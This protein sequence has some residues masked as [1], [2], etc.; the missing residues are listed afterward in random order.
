MSMKRAQSLLI[1][2][3]ALGSLGCAPIIRVGPVFRVV[4]TDSKMRVGTWEVTVPASYKKR[5]SPTKDYLIA[6]NESI[7]ID[8]A[9]I[10]KDRNFDLRRAFEKSIEEILRREKIVTLKQV[11]E[12]GKAHGL[13]SILF[14]A[15]VRFQ[16]N[17]IGVIMMLASESKDTSGL[18]FARIVG[19][20]PESVSEV[21]KILKALK[22]NQ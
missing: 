5:L 8:L 10:R 19:Q 16:S 12:L 21:E 20:D 22:C 13:D 3:V 2:T 15:D 14:R 11:M 6:E 17:D 9:A 4:D 7:R 1:T 18:V